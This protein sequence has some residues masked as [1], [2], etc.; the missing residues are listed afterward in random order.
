MVTIVLSKIVIIKND[1]YICSGNEQPGRINDFK[2]AIVPKQ[3]E[4]IRRKPEHEEGSN[5]I[6]LNQ[7]LGDSNRKLG[8]KINR[9]NQSSTIVVQPFQKSSKNV[10]GSVTRTKKTTRKPKSD[11]MGSNVRKKFNKDFASSLLSTKHPI[12][13]LSDNNNQ[14]VSSPKQQRTTNPNSK[15]ASTVPSKTKKKSFWSDLMDL[16]YIKK[17]LNY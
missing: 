15:T 2:K 12:Q 17:V 4:E 8:L 11:L 14:V 1:W 9:K 13:K 10:K 6:K 7:P 3:D 16:Y 5:I